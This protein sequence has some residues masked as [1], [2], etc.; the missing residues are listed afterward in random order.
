MRIVI[1]TKGRTGRQK[2]FSFLSP[3]L[4]KITDIVC[5]EKEA[6]T[7]RT[8]RTDVNVVVQADPE[9]TIAQKRKWIMEE[10]AR[11]GHEKIVM[12]DDDLEWW[13]R[14]QDGDWHLRY[15][16]PA[17]ADH[18][19]GELESKLS[20][21][22]PHAGFGP[23]QGNNTQEP[24]WASPGRM[25]YVLGYYLPTVLRECELGRIENREDMDVTLQLL[26]KG[27]PNEVNHWICAGQGSYGMYGGCTGQ[28][29]VE[30]A[31]ADALK[32]AE[33]HPGYVRVVDKAYKSSTPRLEV[34]CSWAKAL[35]DGRQLRSKDQ[36]RDSKVA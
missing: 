1:P 36:S 27:Y 14:K 26:R 24:V 22:T 31:N 32:L 10:W 30:Q 13:I 8:W 19:F 34:V 3:A 35:K 16:E 18:W 20:E 9:F 15:V 2:T 25:M 17:D 23:R 11:Q 4:R 33:L 6:E 7:F 12:L 21:D 29:T 28:R 5:P